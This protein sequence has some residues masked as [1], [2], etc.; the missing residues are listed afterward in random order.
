MQ[1][2]RASSGGLFEAFVVDRGGVWELG[3]SGGSRGQFHDE[4]EAVEEARA[5]VRENGGG[6]IRLYRRGRDEPDV[7]PVPS[8]DKGRIAHPEAV[9]FDAEA[10]APHASADVESAPTSSTSYNALRDTYREAYAAA[11]RLDTLNRELVHHVIAH[12]S[13]AAADRLVTRGDDA[14]VAQDAERYAAAAARDDHLTITVVLANRV[15]TLLFGSTLLGLTA[16]AVVFII[17][18]LGELFASSEAAGA[19]V[20]PGEVMAFLGSGGLMALLARMAYVAAQ[21]ASAA[22]RKVAEDVREAFASTERAQNIVR[23]LA[24]AEEA[25]F[26][27]ATPFRLSLARSTV[28]AAGAGGAALILIA[29]GFPLVIVCVAIA[30][31][32]SGFTEANSTT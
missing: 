6:T 5:A 13:R 26:G 19:Q 1:G 3:Y 31:A 22:G 23:S 8:T 16:A 10:P 20:T 27:S 24:Q 11:D 30:G 18:V 15:S 9:K 21:G 14:A 32:L 25:F 17:N 28:P 7:I 4:E 2:A 12:S 29:V